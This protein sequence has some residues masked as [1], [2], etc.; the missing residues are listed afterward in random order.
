MCFCRVLWQ[1][2]QKVCQEC[3][4]RQ[5]HFQ[6]VASCLL[7]ALPVTDYTSVTF[8]CVREMLPFSRLRL[9]E[10]AIVL[11]FLLVLSSRAYG[12]SPPGDTE[13]AVSLD[14]ED[15]RCHCSLLLSRTSLSH[16]HG[17]VSTALLQTKNKGLA[18][19]FSMLNTP[20]CKSLEVAARYL[21][22]YKGRHS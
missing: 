7:W 15:K 11:L 5:S 17:T 8:L 1:C 4:R 18:P 10:P 2:F 21:Y 13:W 22:I 6:Q 9:S 19:F 20:F 14:A 12:W 3:V 16:C